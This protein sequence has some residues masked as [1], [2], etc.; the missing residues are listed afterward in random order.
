[1]SWKCLFLHKWKITYI[2]RP[3]LNY[4]KFYYTCSRCVEGKTMQLQGKWTIDENGKPMRI[5]IKKEK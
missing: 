2:T 1:M 5:G 4:S 3:L